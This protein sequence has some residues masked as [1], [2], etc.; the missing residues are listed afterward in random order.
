[1]PYVVLLKVS[2]VKLL[3]LLK[4]ECLALLKLD[5]NTQW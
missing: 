5:Q 2:F 3:S 1:V 4:Y